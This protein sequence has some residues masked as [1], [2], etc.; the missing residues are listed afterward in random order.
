MGRLL[1]GKIPADS[2]HA[3]IYML[4]RPV[5]TQKDAP[6]EVVACASHCAARARI[7]MDTYLHITMHYCMFV[8]R[9]VD[10]H[11]LVANSFEKNT[12]PM[13]TFDLWMP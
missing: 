11:F 7:H 1:S 12:R 9:N 13:D 10:L 2:W 3:S 8:A 6:S 4:V 5:L